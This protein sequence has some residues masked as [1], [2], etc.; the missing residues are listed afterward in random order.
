MDRD[1]A[2][3]KVDCKLVRQQPAKPAWMAVAERNNGSLQLAATAANELK[4]SVAP[5]NG[6]GK[7]AMAARSKAK[8]GKCRGGVG[9]VDASTQPGGAL[10]KYLHMQQRP[11]NQ[12]AGTRGGQDPREQDQRVLS[13][14]D[15]KTPQ[16]YRA[17]HFD[18][19]KFF[20]HVNGDGTVTDAVGGHFANRY[21]GRD[22]ARETPWGVAEI[23]TEPRVSAA[24]GSAGLNGYGSR[25][26]YWDK[27]NEPVLNNE[28][29]RNYIAPT[30]IPSAKDHTQA[31]A[32]SV[33]AA[34]EEEDPARKGII[35]V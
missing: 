21:M 27:W 10:W 22:D 26:T 23:K 16:L 1:K 4:V 7:V 29:N 20:V 15:G 12:P 24:K 9:G 5:K 8:Q 2:K 13:A 35:V 30:G 18:R 28:P 19:S 14:S 31:I 34:W 6:H 33:L 25:K 17:D 11:A 32:K 3:P